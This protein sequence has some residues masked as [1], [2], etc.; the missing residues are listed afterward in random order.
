[1]ST[2]IVGLAFRHYGGYRKP[3]CFVGRELGVVVSFL[4]VTEFI[5]IFLCRAGFGS[6]DACSR[7]HIAGYNEKFWFFLLNIP[8]LRLDPEYVK[9]T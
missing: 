9:I 1:M 2:N 7:P 3:C 8:S 5:N 4:G 6:H